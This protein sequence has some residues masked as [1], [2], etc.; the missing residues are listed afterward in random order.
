M[1]NWKKIPPK[2]KSLNPTQKYL[3]YFIIFKI[4]REI[5]KL[6]NISSSSYA[7]IG[8]AAHAQLAASHVPSAS[9]V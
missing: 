8:P 2:N 5:I 1:Q 4:L 6:I 7:K 9:R 3:F